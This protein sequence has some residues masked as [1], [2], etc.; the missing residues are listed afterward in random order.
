MEGLI[1]SDSKR[2]YKITNEL[3]RLFALNFPFIMDMSDF[4]SPVTFQDIVVAVDGIPILAELSNIQVYGYV[5]TDSI[6]AI[7]ALTGMEFYQFLSVTFNKVLVFTKVSSGRSPMIAL[8]IAPIRP[9]LIVLHRPAKMDP[10]SIYIANKEN[11]NVVVST[12][13]TEDELLSGLRGLALR[14]NSE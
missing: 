8:K 11:I 13:R 10:L 1:E 7:T 2:G 14:S 5:I 6:K 12:K 4:V 9:K 3:G